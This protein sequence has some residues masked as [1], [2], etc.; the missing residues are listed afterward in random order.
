MRPLLPA[1]LFV[2]LVAATPSPS[3][4]YLTDLPSVPTQRDAITRIVA[5]GIIPPVTAATFNPN[6]TVTRAE[7]AVML[8]RLFSL[9]PPMRVVSY[10]D[11]PTSNPRFS[12]IQAAAPYMNRQAFCFG[13]A[14]STRFAPRQ[15]L[16][17]AEATVV[18]LRVLASQGRVR[19]LSAQAVEATMNSTPDAKEWNPVLAPLLALGVSE[20]IAPLYPGVGLGAKERLTRLHA[21]VLLDNTQRL[22][23]I[24]IRHITGPL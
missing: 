11:V 3:P 8:Q 23:A 7:F 18:I 9:S 22:K 17:R 16:T 19:P 13:C 15:L 24:P 4:V 2:Y 10:P 14:L 1:L 21:A 5:Q 6:G 12:A 20:Q